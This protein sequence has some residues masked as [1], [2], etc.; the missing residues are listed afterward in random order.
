MKNF[1]LKS[2]ILSLITV[3]A[4]SFS[5]CSDSSS[6]AATPSGG[7]D[8]D[9]T[10]V[11]YAGERTI[12][13][14][15]ES[16]TLSNAAA[17]S[18]S[19]SNRANSRAVSEDEIVKLYVMDENGELEDT[20]ITCPVDDT[21]REYTCLDV[22]GDNEYIVRYVKNLGG[23]RVF[24][25]KS[26][27][28]VGDTDPLPAET[29]V[30]KVTTLIVAAITKAVEEAVVSIAGI[31][32]AAVEALVAQV[33]TAVVQSV[34]S[35]ISQGLISVPDDSSMV[36]TL[37]ANETFDEFI[38]EETVEENTQL[39][40]DAGAIISDE[41]VTQVVDNTKNEA[42]V[43]EYDTLTNLEIIKAIFNQTSEDEKGDIENWIAEFLAD[44]YTHAYTLADLN[45]KI[46]F[47]AGGD[48][49]MLEKLGIANDIPAA[50]A[51][52]INAG[53]SDETMQTG[54]ED[55]IALVI[56]DNKTEAE[57]ETVADIPPIIRYVFADGI[58]ETG[59]T[60]IAQALVYV[61]YAE[62]VFAKEVTK[63]YF[64]T[65]S[66]DIPGD[67]EQI[68]LVEFNPE[69]LFQDLGM[70]ETVA[71][72]YDD[73]EV[74]YFELRTDSFWDQDGQKEFMTF[75]AYLSK[76]S[77]MM[78]A[79]FTYD[80]DLLE[81]VTLEYPI[82]STATET[83]EVLLTKVEARK[84][85]GGIGIGYNPWAQCQDAT[86][87]C[88]PDST[89]M[90]VTN[91]VSGDYTV[92]VVYDGETFTGTFDR[93][94]LKNAM[95]LSPQLTSP[96]SRPNWPQ[97]LMNTDPGAFLTTEQQ[98]AQ[99]AFHLAEQEFMQATNFAGFMSFAPN[100][101]SSGDG[102]DD[103]IKDI[104]IKWDDSE[105]K[106]ALE[107]MTL[108][109]NIIPAYELGISL[110]EPDTDGDGNATQ[111][112]QEQC[113]QNWEECNTEIFNTWWDNRPIRGTSYMLTQ[114]LP[115]NSGE[116]RYNVNINLVFIDKTT[117]RQVAR[118][119]QSHS[120]FKVG[121]VEG[122]TGEEDIIFNGEVKLQDGATRPSYLRVALI[123]EQCTYNP[124]TF[125]HDCN[126]TT[127]DIALPDPA[128]GDYSLRANA[129]E[130][131]NEFAGNNPPH[132]NIIAFSD[133]N[134]NNQWNPWK[135]DMDGTT[136][137]GEDAW[138]LDTK[139]FWFETWGEFRVSVDSWDHETGESEHESLRVPTDGSD[140]AIDGLDI[141]IWNYGYE[142]VPTD[143]PIDNTDGAM[144]YFYL[145][146]QL[147]D[148]AGPLAG[149]PVNMAVFGTEISGTI[150]TD[151]FLYGQIDEDTG[152]AATTAT[153]M[154]GIEVATC[155]GTP[156]M[157]VTGE[158][159]SVTVTV[160]PAGSSTTFD[161]TLYPAT[162]FGQTEFVS[163]AIGEMSPAPLNVSGTVLYMAMN[164]CIDSTCTTSYQT[165]EQITFGVDTISW[166]QVYRSD[167]GTLESG[168]DAYTYTDGVLDITVTE[169][170]GTTSSEE[171]TIVGVYENG[172][173]ISGSHTEDD[174]RV[175][176]F[177][178]FLFST[179]EG[180]QAHLA[181]IP[182]PTPI[183]P[184]TTTTGD[185][186]VV[187]IADLQDNTLWFA[188]TATI[189]GVMEM[190]A[191]KVVFGT[192]TRRFFLIDIE[193]SITGPVYNTGDGDF[194]YSLEGNTLSIDRAGSGLAD[195]TVI[196][197]PISAVPDTMPVG[198]AIYAA[199]VTLD[200][201]STFSSQRI[202]FSSETDLFN[203]VAQ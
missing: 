8:D 166:T 40:E 1:F 162:D 85:G 9:G 182:T 91:H 31:D 28:S 151:I 163:P 117:G 132:F 179:L 176:T 57:E 149:L 68:R 121:A 195:V 76:A 69:F 97:E 18:P 120:E 70:N 58:S 115:E 89:M 94:V 7:G 104:I 99:D 13:G 86:D 197:A 107:A 27:V 199:S 60:N 3:T 169:D 145:Q 134:N 183:A 95:N 44:N 111:A 201:V 71:A 45:T 108:P 129:Q 33:K 130:I 158:L 148:T 192:T 140:L 87:Y 172:V 116:G 77:W 65:N 173:E 189:N 5:A 161:Y 84:E 202:Y 30:S 106:T 193:A 198:N 156:N 90:D 21:T 98:A 119:G 12:T 170:D 154:N 24:E 131:R 146:G 16:T 180:A 41:S 47:A 6:T 139:W 26:S 203:F 81:S 137:I 100:H 72:Q 171:I 36:T 164:E 37:D 174:G 135:P 152:L 23:G 175:F 168:N 67:V 56:K 150:G 177:K 96:L 114:E 159:E 62:E 184:V 128:S 53:I 123:K 142:Y 73:P 126:S 83:K 29:S 4:L 63:Y 49:Y 35:L 113:W 59:F 191:G 103:S 153:D 42:K 167:S 105:I 112:E 200:G 109:E 38:A 43:D 78:D 157:N 79:N 11:S 34:N 15:V 186:P 46:E 50:V 55:L 32:A 64:D 66:I 20:G 125:T 93:F 124:D 118:G 51:E 178:E 80:A 10:T 181:T 92:T 136:E 2:A 185:D 82:S 122:L 138:W 17:L 74:N 187:T 19:R 147:P 110:Y 160:T 48:T 22:A 102:T 75:F 54:F 144:D 155:V 14:A 101:D 194:P 52:N 88:G 165:I 196:L 25:M 190:R 39:A 143:D 133:A 141:N 188:E 61:L 127:V